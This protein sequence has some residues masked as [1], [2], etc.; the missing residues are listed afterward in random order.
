MT[1]THGTLSRRN[2]FAVSGLAAGALAASR[3]AKAEPA[4]SAPALPVSV[5]KVRTYEEDLVA[6]F[7]KMFDQLGGLASQVRGKTVAMKLNLTGG[8]R[9][10]GYTAGETHWVHPRVVGALTAVFCKL[11]ARRVRIL[12]SAGRR[13]GSKLEDKL[14]SG[15]WDVAAIQNAAPVVE[16]EDTNYPG[17]GHQYPTFKVKWK[18]YIYRHSI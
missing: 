10:E 4:A 8:N 1:D 12:E 9:F 18:P 6:Q 16:F 2:V 11:G 15:G 7:E 5:A 3:A 17:E 14:L 13:A